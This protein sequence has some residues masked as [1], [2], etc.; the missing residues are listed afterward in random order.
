M[1]GSTGRNFL[2][3]LHRI[4]LPPSSSRVGWGPTARRGRELCQ[5]THTTLAWASPRDV[6]DARRSGEGC[7]VERSPPRLLGGWRG[8]L[9][10]TKPVSD[11][12]AEALTRRLLVSP[13]WS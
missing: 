11:S 6:S 12:G 3:R 1:H 5:R 8:P 9:R 10:S 2:T 4:Y 7:W 13:L